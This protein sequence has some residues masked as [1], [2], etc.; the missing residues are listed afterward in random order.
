MSF[1]ELKRFFQVL[2]KWVD[3][4]KNSDRIDR[5]PTVHLNIPQMEL[6]WFEVNSQHKGHSLKCFKCISVTTDGLRSTYFHSSHKST[7]LFIKK[8]NSGTTFVYYLCLCCSCVTIMLFLLYYLTLWMISVIIAR[9]ETYKHQ[10]DSSFFN[11]DI[12]NNVCIWIIF[13]CG[14]L[15][16]F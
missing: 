14:V 3:F 2:P 6:H 1:S 9:N 12:A 13:L 8:Y 5:V 15:Y 11:P 7:P 10:T 4:P 16:L